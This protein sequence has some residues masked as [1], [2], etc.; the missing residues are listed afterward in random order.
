MAW[1]SVHPRSS[2]ANLRRG[3]GFAKY[4][5][6]GLQSH[7]ESDEQSQR[8]CCHEEHIQTSS[9]FMIKALT[10]SRTESA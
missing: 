9:P 4:F 6:T 10:T 5:E 2:I 7:P 3:Q 1:D 8:S